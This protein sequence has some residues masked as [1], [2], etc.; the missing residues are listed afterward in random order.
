MRVLLT[1]VVEQDYEKNPSREGHGWTSNNS[2]FARVGMDY[3]RVCSRVARNG[4]PGFAWLDNMRAYG[5]MSDPANDRDR[6]AEG[7]NPCL[8]QTLESFELCCLVETFPARHA[9]LDDFLRTLKA[10][11]L[12]AKTVT[13]GA[14]RWPESNRVMLRNRRI[15]CSMSGIA[16]FITQRGLHALHDWCQAGY[17][18]VQLCD[19][20]VSEWLAVPRSIKS[21]CIKPSGTVSL[22]A[23]AT[24]GM[25]YPE[26]RF[27]I[28]RVRL[29]STSDLLEPVRRAG[30]PVE[31]C[32]TTPDTAVVEIP[33]DVGAGIRT[34][35]DVSLWEQLELAAF[36]QA[37]WA[38][39]QVSATVS[40]DAE[41]EGPHLAPAL[42]YFQYR[43]KGVSFLP[44]A[45]RA[46][47]PAYAQMP[48]EEI[49]EG[50]YRRRLA[51][52]QPGFTLRRTNRHRRDFVADRFC[53]SASCT[54]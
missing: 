30:Y 19:E 43:L 36:L 12:Y 18:A 8:E 13:L 17:A 44:R 7:G 6:R 34:L 29:A 45:P 26:S 49:D 16:Q 2:V 24:P 4:E 38:D 47:A 53:D 9:S 42:Q 31:P 23:G 3:E 46:S 15:G 25:H 28:R 40:F 27:Y 54:I 22:L 33:V 37:Y 20:R 39:N 48:Y 41:R 52:I 10:A 21:T 14:T 5:R 32:A 35:R 1:G 11:L 50:E 51:A